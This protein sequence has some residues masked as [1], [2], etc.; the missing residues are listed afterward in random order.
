MQACCD[1]TFEYV[2]TRKQ[3]GQR[4]G[5]FQV[6]LFLEEI[7]IKEWIIHLKD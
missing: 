1:I 3:F 4:I 2:H 7:L 6:M 5:E